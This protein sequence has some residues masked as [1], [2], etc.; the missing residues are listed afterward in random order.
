[1]PWDWDGAVWADEFPTAKH[2]LSKINV[3]L[4]FSDLG[5]VIGFVFLMGR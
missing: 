3:A 5:R 1:V 4:V 2:M